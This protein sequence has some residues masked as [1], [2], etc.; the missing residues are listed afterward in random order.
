MRGAI[1]APR[2]RRG[3]RAQRN[4]GAVTT[5]FK[6]E[7][8]T[9]DRAFGAVIDPAGSSFLGAPGIRLGIDLRGSKEPE[10]APAQGGDNEQ[11]GHDEK[12]PKRAPA[13]READIGHAATFG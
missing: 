11:D 2:S 1:T 7:R 4:A 10:R 12:P 13:R 3:L 8:K 5:H 9:R 6:A